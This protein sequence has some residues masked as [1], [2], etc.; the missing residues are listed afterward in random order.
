VRNDVAMKR[1]CGIELCG[2]NALKTIPSLQRYVNMKFLRL[3]LVFLLV[4]AVSHALPTRPPAPHSPSANTSISKFDPNGAA[5]WAQVTSLPP[6][7]SHWCLIAILIMIPR[8]T[9]PLVP[10]LLERMLRLRVQPRHRSRHYPP[11]PFPV[12][13]NTSLCSLVP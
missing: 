2:F 5:G 1:I 10:E 7:S 12:P 13:L 4:A 6:C 9:R 8:D 3:V 11:H